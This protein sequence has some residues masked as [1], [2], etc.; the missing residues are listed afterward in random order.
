M[1]ELTYPIELR[2]EQLGLVAAGT[3]TPQQNPCGCGGGGHGGLIDVQT[4]DINVLNNIAVLSV[5]KQ[6]VL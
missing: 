1:H 5:A 4:G 2:D 6:F 3:G